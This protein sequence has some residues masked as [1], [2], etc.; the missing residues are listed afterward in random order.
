MHTTQKRTYIRLRNIEFAP[1][2]PLVLG[3]L[4]TKS[5]VPGS[6]VPGSSAIPPSASDIQ[7]RE[8]CDWQDDFM[9][10][11][12]GS[13]SVFGN[14]L[15]GI[16]GTAGFGFNRKKATRITA[17]VA[18]LETV[19][20]VPSEDYLNSVLNSAAVQT[21]LL[22]NHFHANLYMVTGVKIAYGS[23]ITSSSEKEFGWNTGINMTG[24]IIST[25]VRSG[26]EATNT[27]T[28]RVGNSHQHSSDFVYAYQVKEIHYCKRRTEIVLKDVIGGALYSYDGGSEKRD[29]F[30]DVEVADCEVSDSAMLRVIGE[31][32]LTAKDMRAESHL[33]VDEIG[34]ECEIVACL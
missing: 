19:L 31:D 29:S 1:T 25:P 26:L 27:S 18:R 13:C 3:S 5:R 2:G 9:Q 23:V 28:Q 12:K 8:Q 10:D 22:E 11:Y 4:L 21:Y 7:H 32:F 17:K 16:F 33:A 20:F 30:G 14:F 24:S 6:F 15:E 34:I